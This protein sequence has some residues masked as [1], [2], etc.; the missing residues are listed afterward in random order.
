M[1]IVYDAPFL[2][3][4]IFSSSLLYHDDRKQYEYD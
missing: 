1:E 2:L 3:T 4:S